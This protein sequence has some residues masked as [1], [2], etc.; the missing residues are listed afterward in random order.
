LCSSSL[1]RGGLTVVVAV[2][3]RVAATPVNQSKALTLVRAK[4]R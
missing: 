4:H 1:E 2:R 3:G